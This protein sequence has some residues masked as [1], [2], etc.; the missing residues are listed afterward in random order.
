MANALRDQAARALADEAHALAG[1]AGLMGFHRLSSAARALEDRCRAGEC[2]RT[3]FASA[4]TA[5]DAAERVLAGWIA[6]L[7]RAIEREAAA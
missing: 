2:S 6:R 7:E 5:V 4:R 3:A 1:S